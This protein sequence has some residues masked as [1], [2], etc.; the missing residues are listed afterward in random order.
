MIRLTI[1]GPSYSGK[2]TFVRFLLGIPFG[3][4]EESSIGT[5]YCR[6]K[7]LDHGVETEYEIWDTLG[8]ERYMS[9]VPFYLR[10]THFVVIV[11]DLTDDDCVSEA[12]RFLQI[13]QSTDLENNKHYMIIG[14]KNDRMDWEKGDEKLNA[15]MELAEST[16]ANFVDVSFKT[17]S[18]TD[19]LLSLCTEELVKINSSL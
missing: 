10:A 14:T 3:E 5:C 16:N 19:M 8:Y 2:S 18:N 12:K 11:V 6:G 1:I 7:F 17:G 4:K 15:L 9:L 13:A